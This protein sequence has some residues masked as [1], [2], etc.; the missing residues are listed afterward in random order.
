MF[1]PLQE[2]F[3]ASRK[4]SETQFKT[5]EHR[6]EDIETRLK[7]AE[8]KL[9]VVQNTRISEEK[10]IWE[11]ETCNRIAQ[12]GLSHH[13]TAQDAVTDRQCPRS[14]INDYVRRKVLES[15]ESDLNEVKV[16]WERPSLQ[17]SRLRY[18]A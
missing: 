12:G 14:G 13:T 18:C 17:K 4:D 2:E 9:E 1:N 3:E 6:L 16:L 7:D 5:L 10:V 8:R 11:W 15:V